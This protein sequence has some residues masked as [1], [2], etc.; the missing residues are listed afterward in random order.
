[1][2]DFSNIIL[3]PSPT[4]GEVNALSRVRR[5]NLKRRCLRIQH[6]V[7]AALIA[8]GFARTVRPHNQRAQG[9]PGVQRARSLAC[10]VKWHTS[11]VTTVT[12]ELPGIP[13]AMV[14]RLISCSPRRRVLVVTVTRGL[15]FCLPGRADEPPRI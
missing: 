12:P 10:D 9:M 1:M 4:R 2:L 7:P 15:R 6:R 5:F 14:L 11:V 3:T 8:R 13:R